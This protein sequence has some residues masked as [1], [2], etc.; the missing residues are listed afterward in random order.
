MLSRFSCVCV[1]GGV[2]K[3]YLLFWALLEPFFLFGNVKESCLSDKLLLKHTLPY[4]RDV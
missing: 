2:S 3:R 4:Y 1:L